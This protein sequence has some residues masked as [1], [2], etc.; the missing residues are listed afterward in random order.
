M[1]ALSVGDDQARVDREG[2]AAH[3]SL[4][5]AARD[6]GFEETAQQI[7]LAEAPMTVSDVCFHLRFAENRR[8]AYGPLLPF[9]AH[10][11]RPAGHSRYSVADIRL[12]G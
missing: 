8:S 2:F 1:T 7:A 12:G 11:G 4:R 3:K 6:H 9:R 5:H 10:L